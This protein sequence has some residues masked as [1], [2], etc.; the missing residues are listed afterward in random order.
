[1][2]FGPPVSLGSGLPISVANRAPTGRTHPCPLLAH[3][4]SGTVGVGGSGLR[5]LGAG[6]R[7]RGGGGCGPP[8]RSTRGDCRLAGYR[9]RHQR[10]RRGRECL[11]P[12]GSVFL[13]PR[14]GDVVVRPGAVQ[15]RGASS[16]STR[17]TS[18]TGT[19]TTGTPSST[20]ATGPA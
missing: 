3:L 4:G 15:A 5:R 17:P 10:D 6:A 14:A 7:Q 9:P 16:S 13:S 19:P 1:M 11:H 20:A 12:R 2:G 18:P 8:R